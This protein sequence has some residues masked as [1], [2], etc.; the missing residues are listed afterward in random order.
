VAQTQDVPPAQPIEVVERPPVEWAD[1][2]LKLTGVR[3]TFR[4]RETLALQFKSAME[5]AVAKERYE[6]DKAGASRVTT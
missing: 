2:W 4:E 3:T 1:A 5:Y 6:R